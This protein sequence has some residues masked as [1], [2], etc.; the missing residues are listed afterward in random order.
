MLSELGP[1]VCTSSFRQSLRA[2]ERGNH[3]KPNTHDPGL[4]LKWIFFYIDL[5]L[6][7]ESGVNNE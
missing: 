1:D 5:G 2:K 7:V 3:E 4:F 6:R